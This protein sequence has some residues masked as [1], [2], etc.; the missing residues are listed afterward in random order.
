M[1][2]QALT[3]HDQ[4]STAMKK[5]LLSCIRFYQKHLSPLTPPCCIYLPSCSQYMAEAIGKYGAA[6]GL[7]LGL[8]RICRCH[9]WHRG[10]YDPVP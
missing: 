10:G 1:H 2:C 7:W 8:K 9:P 6:K 3:R 5:I 4:K